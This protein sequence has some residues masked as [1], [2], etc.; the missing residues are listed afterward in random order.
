MKLRHNKKRNTA[1]LYETLIKELTKSVVEKNLKRKAELQS[2][3]KEAFNK[4][5]V[6]SKELSLYRTLY[7][8]SNL[9]TKTA[10][11]LLQEVKR[12]HA[13]IDKKKL[14]E[15]QS[16]LISK[17]N[18]ILSKGVYSN[19]VPNFKSLA[20]IYQV[21]NEE[22]PIK[23]R[24]LMEEGILGTL[25]NKISAAK[26]N[27]KPIDNIVYNTFVDKFNQEYVGKLL[28]EQKT[29]LNKYI[30]SFLDNGIELKV[31]LNEEIG[32]LKKELNSSISMEE[33]SSD[34]EMTGKTKKVLKMLEEFKSIRV[35]K[36]LVQKVLKIQDLVQEIKS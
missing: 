17:M 35:D 27:L 8:T 18:K 21:F 10:E 16:S 33:I 25:T 34:S 29:L 12:Q 5:T 13:N 28:S 9:A 24:I 36:S 20:T 1:F 22:T 31:Y 23:K 15:E 6:L 32:R 26:E 7:E 4:N 19:F 11:K 3:V 14:F 30:T 2:L